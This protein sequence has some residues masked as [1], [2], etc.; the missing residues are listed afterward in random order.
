MKH[1]VNYAIVSGRGDW[2]YVAPGETTVQVETGGPI[3]ARGPSGFGNGFGSGWAQI[4]SVWVPP[5]GGGSP[6]ILKEIGG[7][8][9]K[10]IQGRHAGNGHTNELVY[11]DM[12]ARYTLLTNV[13]LV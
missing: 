10:C 13:G 6:A 5:S 9:P 12:S 2:S 11:F 1:R 4:T 8:A 3:S 7:G